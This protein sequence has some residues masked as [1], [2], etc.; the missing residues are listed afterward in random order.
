MISAAL[1]AIAVDR[2]VT[3]KA[4]RSLHVYVVLH[5]VLDSRQ[6]RPVKRAWLAARCGITERQVMR[7]VRHLLILGY[8]DRG[9]NDCTLPN[10]PTRTY[11]LT[12][13][14]PPVIEAKTYTRGDRR[15][16]R[17]L[18]SPQKVA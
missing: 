13:S 11:R 7:S 15:A 4:L 18:L 6:P 10:R 3:R 16:R 9:P 12:D 5:T 8:L 1:A 2:R 14:P 17:R